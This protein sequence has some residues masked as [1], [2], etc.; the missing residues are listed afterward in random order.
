MGTTRRK[1]TLE[2]KT[3]AAHRVIGAGTV[4]H[5]DWGRQFDDAKV[6]A[7]CERADLVRSMAAS[8]RKLLAK[9]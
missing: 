5:P 8:G 9:S 4:L 1:F 6:V 7:F 2:F 3:E